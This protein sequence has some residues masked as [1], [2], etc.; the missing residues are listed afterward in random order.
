MFETASPNAKAQ[1]SRR[2][3]FGQDEEKNGA[4]RRTIPSSSQQVSHIY[5]HLLHTQN[6]G[7]PKN[8]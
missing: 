2:Q 7:V 5:I 1:V 3:G 4:W 6:V 8:E